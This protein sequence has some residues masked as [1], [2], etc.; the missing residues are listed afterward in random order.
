MRVAIVEDENAA[1]ERLEAYLNRFSEESGEK[2]AVKRFC[3]PVGLLNRYAG[4]DLVLMD[5]EMPNMDGME[6]ARRLREIDRNAKL[7]F[8]T[9]MAQYAA[10]GYEIDAMDFLVKPVAY[11]DFAFKMKRASNAVRI[12]RARELTI[13]LPGGMVRENANELV[14]VEVL[15]HR[16]TYHF[17]DHEVEARG[18]IGSVKETL[19][20]LNL[21]IPHNSYLINPKFIDRVQSY[22]VTVNGVELPISRN[23]RKEFLQ[24]LAD[25]YARG[26]I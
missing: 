18:S 19:K 9:N 8:V 6:G 12:G 2:V 24:E 3:D 11:S 21:L 1:A 10:K 20:E 25:R 4:F 5:I 7:I 14:Y 17:M 26:G 15:G 22:T 16:L 13:L 23:R